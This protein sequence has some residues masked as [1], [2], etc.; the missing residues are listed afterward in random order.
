[1]LALLL[2]ML[3]LIG[4]MDVMLLQVPFI[5]MK[6]IK[7][8]LWHVHKHGVYCNV[9]MIHIKRFVILNLILIV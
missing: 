2:H 3:E 9:L 6:N 7:L 4:M 8:M 1:M 5:V